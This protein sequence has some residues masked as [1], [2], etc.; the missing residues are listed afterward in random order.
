MSTHARAY[1][2]VVLLARGVVVRGKI[3]VMEKYAEWANEPDARRHAAEDALGQ[4]IMQS[5]QCIMQVHARQYAALIPSA[6]PEEIQSLARK[7]ALDG[8]YA[9]VMLLDG[10]ASSSLDE[11][12]GVEYSLSARILE[13]KVKSTE[14]KVELPQSED[15][16]VLKSFRPSETENVETIE[17][18]P[19]GDGLCYAFH[20]WLE[21]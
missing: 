8:I 19:E 17:L 10:V 14:V 7:A 3:K 11:N 13:F 2:V 20:R 18:T 12:H 9:M 21:E 4:H 1:F 16:V 5:L 6:S 15:R